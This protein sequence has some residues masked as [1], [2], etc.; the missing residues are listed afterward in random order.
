MIRGTEKRIFISTNTEHE[1]L[2]VLRGYAKRWPVEPMF[3]QLKH[4]FGCCHLWQ[5]KLRTLLRWMHLK[6]AGYALLQ[7]LTV[8]KNQSCLTISR[9][10]WRSP[11][12]TTAGMMRISL[13]RIIPR[14]PIR[15]GWDRY[16]QK[17]ELNF[18]EL[19]GQLKTDKVEAA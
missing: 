10:P 1:G 15:K 7:L 17:Y 13:S 3:H 8:C 4:A 5:Q 16:H 9:I 18:N 2:D 12:T 19:S 14:F 6:M 11:D